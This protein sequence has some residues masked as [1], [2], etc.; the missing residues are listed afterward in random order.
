MVCPRPASGLVALEIGVKRGAAFWDTIAVLF[1]HLPH[2]IA[3][4]RAM[5]DKSPKNNAKA[6]KQKTTK[7]APKEAPVK[8]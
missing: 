5:G 3:G 4:V 8:K 1:R 6:T 7:T 2:P